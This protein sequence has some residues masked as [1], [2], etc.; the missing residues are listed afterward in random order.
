MSY[1]QSNPFLKFLRQ[2]QHYSV[3]TLSHHMFVLFCVPEMHYVDA[4][5]LYMYVL[6]Y[7]TSVCVCVR[8]GQHDFY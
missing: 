5:H 4:K 8:N 3:H 1:K 6:Y 2:E 7:A